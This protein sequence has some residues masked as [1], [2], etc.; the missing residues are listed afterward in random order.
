MTTRASIALLGGS[1]LAAAAC[2]QYTFIDLDPGPIS[3]YPFSTCYGAA[4]TQQVGQVN[5]AGSI[6]D[7]TQ[8]VLWGGTAASMISL[9][10]PGAEFSFCRGTDGVTQVGMA[11]IG[12]VNSAVLWSGS[13][14]TVV[15]L[16]PV[17]SSN[18]SAS[19]VAGGRQAGEATMGGSTHAILWFGSASSYADLNPPDA[20]SS[21][22]TGVSASDV[23]GLANIDLGGR[24]GTVSHAVIWPGTTSA[25]V[26]LNPVWALQSYPNGTDGVQQVGSAYDGFMNRA[27]V[28]NGHSSSAVDLTPPGAT[29]AIAYGV[30]NGRQCGMVQ[31]S[32]GAYAVVWSGTAASMVDLTAFT[33]ADYTY[34][35][36]YGITAD[37]TV[38]GAAYHVPMGTNRAVMWKPAVTPTWTFVGFLQPL[39]D[40]A[41][42]ESSFRKNSTV[43]IKFS[44]LDDN[45]DPVTGEQPT[46]SLT[47]LGETEVQVNE[48]DFLTPSDTGNVFLEIT[49]GNYRYNLGTK[50]LLVGRYRV[51]ATVGTL[52]HSV[53]ITIR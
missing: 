53:T 51:T 7:V 31:T 13:A 27:I 15:N 19:S 43:P 23:V 35:A 24:N 52:S 38:V 49:P 36:A 2:A 25:Y 44:L 11:R 50:N 28:W 18:S 22:A 39:N 17:G 29:L 14:G 12:G 20:L 21:Y 48:S 45:G 26:D 10:P 47:Y 8:A 1:V 40:P 3:T 37:G 9:H 41:N 34:A 4:G 16:N 32:T 46:I 33:P 6:N 42:P 5:F 30:S